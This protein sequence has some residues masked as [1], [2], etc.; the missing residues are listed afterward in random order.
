MMK[1]KDK[2]KRKTKTV[3]RIK[4]KETQSRKDWIKSK[5]IE[6][7]SPYTAEAPHGKAL[8]VVTFFA[9]HR[10]DWP[11]KGGPKSELSLLKFTI[12][13]ELK[14]D[15]GMPMDMLLVNHYPSEKDLK[16][17]KKFEDKEGYESYI[18]YF[19]SLSGTKTKN[20]KIITHNQENEIGISTL[21]WEYAYKTYK[22]DYDFWYFCEDDVITVKDDVMRIAANMLIQNPHVFLI[23]T[24]GWWKDKTSK[25][26]VARGTIGVTSTDHIERFFI[27]SDGRLMDSGIKETYWD[28][29]NKSHDV[30]ERAISIT[31][32]LNE[33]V[34]IELLPLRYSVVKWK[35]D[36]FRLDSGPDVITAW[37]PEMERF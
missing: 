6:K 25:K 22:N 1:R 5:M 28:N 32:Q 14:N 30:A 10:R 19:N 37:N 4:Y 18:N 15:Y 31:P 34:T 3:H 2:V 8:K 21:G 35:H 33:E 24:L 23:S 16:F 13:Q 17:D 29:K 20:G 12:E 7:R 27:Q 36:H 9:G 26:R 11:D